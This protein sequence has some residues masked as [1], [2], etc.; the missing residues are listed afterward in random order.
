M[1]NTFH[2]DPFIIGVDIDDT[3]VPY[4]EE[5][6]ALLASELNVPNES[7]KRPT[8][9]D[10]GGNGWPGINS[11]ADYLVY[12][13]EFVRRGMFANA[14]AFDYAA[15]AL[16]NLREAG[17]YIKIITTR[18]CSPDEVDKAIVIGETAK[19]LVNNAI[20]YDEFSISS[21]KHQIEAHVYV[22]DS[23]SNLKR[24]RDRG[25]NA[26]VPN[27]TGYTEAAAAQFNYPLMQDWRHGEAL[28]MEMMKEHYAKQETPAQAVL[29]DFA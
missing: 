29:F 24:F 20:S 4:T 12:H 7:L 22:D 23:P 1:A 18:F 21:T 27:T 8:S 11:T 2:G 10:M 3:L 25:L 19:F 17:A 6:L 28:I 16:S 5:F 15:E 14:K 13:N 26:L 9:Y